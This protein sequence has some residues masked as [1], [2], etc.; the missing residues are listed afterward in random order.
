MTAADLTPA[1]AAFSAAIAQGTGQPQRAFSAL[2]DLTRATIGARL[3][4]VMRFDA[5]R[6]VAARLFSSDPLAYP[7]AG[8]KPVR[9]D[10]WSEQVLVRKQ[11]FIANDLAAIA[12]VFSDH[13]Q[14]AALGCQSCLNLPLIIGGQVLGTLNCLDV[15]GH[16]TPQRVAQ[17]A[18][19]VAPGLVAMSLALRLA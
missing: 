5:D 1:L 8:E 15:A 18:C 2:H 19:L 17:A 6:G 4:T 3:F 16:Y 12:E 7:P 11:P 10:R 13:A 9:P 14:I